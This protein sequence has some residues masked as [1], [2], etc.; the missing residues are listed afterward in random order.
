MGFTPG[1]EWRV[2]IRPIFMN[3]V[4]G[5]YGDDYQCLIFRGTAAAMPTVEHDGDSE[6][7]ADVEFTDEVL[8]TLFPNPSRTGHFRI[9]WLSEDVVDTQVEIWDAMGR[10]VGAW[11]FREASTMEMDGANWESGVYQIRISRGKETHR[12]RWMKI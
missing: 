8:P 12:L 1:S 5:S 7:S 2:Q 11:T 4:V 9:D 6:K 10:K 3:G